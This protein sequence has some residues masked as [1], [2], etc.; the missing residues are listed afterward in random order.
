V[1]E[2]KAGLLQVQETI[3]HIKDGLTKMRDMP[4]EKGGSGETLPE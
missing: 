3:L 2:L 4:K 1:R